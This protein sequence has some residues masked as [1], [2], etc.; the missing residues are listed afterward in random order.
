M[1][2]AAAD[3]GEERAVVGRK[4]GRL[5]KRSLNSARVSSFNPEST[6]AA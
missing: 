5:G 4:A 3:D 1:R 6:S 2:T